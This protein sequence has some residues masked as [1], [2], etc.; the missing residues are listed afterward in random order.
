MPKSNRSPVLL[1]LAMGVVGAAVGTVLAMLGVPRGISMTVGVGMVVGSMASLK[2]G[3][4]PNP[5]VMCEGRALFPLSTAPQSSDL[6]APE[7]SMKRISSNSLILVGA[8][9][10]MVA[11]TVKEGVWRL[12]ALG[13]VLVIGIVLGIRARKDF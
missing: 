4:G 13:M 7:C 1:G 11:G 12:V 5:R 10:T 3:D 8:A 9:L 6:F 2:R